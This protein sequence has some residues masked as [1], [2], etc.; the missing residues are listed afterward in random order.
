[1]KLFM[2][3]ISKKYAE[4]MHQAN[5]AIGRKEVVRLLKKAAKVKS[6]LDEQLVA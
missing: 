4:I 2:K 5:T 1:M 6:I 3:K